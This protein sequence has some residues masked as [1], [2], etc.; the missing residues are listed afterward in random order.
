MTTTLTRPTARLSHAGLHTNLRAALS[1]RPRFDQVSALQATRLTA[2]L[3]AEPTMP[4]YTGNTSTPRQS[5]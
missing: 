3:G 5:S 2:V 4:T 1:R